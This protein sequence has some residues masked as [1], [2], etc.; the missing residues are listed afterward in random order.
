[1]IKVFFIIVGWLLCVF[2]A[3]AEPINVLAHPL[4]IETDVRLSGNGG[5][6]TYKGG[7]EL[8]SDDFRFGG[9][10]GLVLDN[11][12]T[13]VTAISDKGWWIMGSLVYDTIGNLAS[14]RFSDI[15]PILSMASVGSEHAKSMDAEAVIRLVNGGLVVAFERD[16]RLWRYQTVFS[17]A[18]SFLLGAAL[19]LFPSNRGIESLALLDEHLLLALSE[20]PDAESTVRGW[21]LDGV[22]LGSFSY[23]YDGYYRPSDAVGLDKEQVLVLERGYT[24]T[25]GVS[26]RLM[27]LD[28][29]QVLKQRTVKAREFVRLIAPLPLDNFEG[30]ALRRNQKGSTYIYFVS[31]DNYSVEQRTL[32]MMFELEY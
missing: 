13:Q 31:D 24:K 28:L 5:A 21:I 20:S 29:A 26:A 16:H 9:L 1:M 14:V 30:L 15:L 11:S 32:L 12:G 19:N 23:H 2:N 7:F 6:I 4:A 27:I 10:S 8:S 18:H 17:H 3:T 22:N 25:R